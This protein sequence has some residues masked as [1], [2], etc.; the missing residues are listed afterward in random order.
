LAAGWALGGRKA[1]VLMQNSGL[2][3]AVNPL[4][5]L[6]RVFEIPCLLA[7]GW[8][9]QPGRPDEPQHALMGEITAP[10]LDLMGVETV[11]LGE[12]PA[13]LDGTL[14]KIDAAILA[15]KPAALL[16]PQGSLAGPGAQA[17]APEG[18]MSRREA[19]QA[20]L[21]GLGETDVVVAT[22]GKISREL[23][24]QPPSKRSQFYMVGSMG[25]APSLAMGVA[26]ARPKRNVVVLDGD[27]ALLMK[28][29]ALATIGH[30]RPANFLHVVLDNG[31]YDSTGG[32]PTTVAGVEID[33]VARAC[34]Y[35]NC[36]RAEQAADIPAAVRDLTAAPGPNLLWIKISPAGADRLG[37]PS[38]TLPQLR[39]QFM[40]NLDAS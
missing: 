30:Y 31:A 7:V 11:I 4:T 33:N 34:G 19:V 3:N 32:Q 28:L 8:R 6:H 29:G 12:D 15:G 5:S 16:I 17:A 9:G 18:R 23:Y 38:E 39:R 37:R 13:A 21:Q 25:C 24:F 35:N 20:I 1:V 26:L 22:T 2:G 40:K 27:G 36:R 14:A 10:M